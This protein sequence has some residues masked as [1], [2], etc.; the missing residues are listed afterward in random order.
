MNIS[1]YVRTSL[2]PDA[3]ITDGWMIMQARKYEPSGTQDC[4][5]N[6]TGCICLRKIITPDSTVQDKAATTGTNMA[7]NNNVL[8]HC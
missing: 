1:R 6:H 3:V 5:I 2:G 8:Q 7:A 4:C